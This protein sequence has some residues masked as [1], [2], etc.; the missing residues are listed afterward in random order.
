MKA[1]AVKE[2]L[3]KKFKSGDLSALRDLLESERDGLYDYLLRMTGQVSRSMETT[4]EV[5]LS[6]NEDTLDVTDNYTELK[7][8]LYTTAR[9]FNADIWNAETSR[10]KNLA[11]EGPP[12]PDDG[13]RKAMRERAI[14][15]V[16]DRQLRTL[17]GR[18]RDLLLLH[19]FAYFDENEISEIT[20]LSTT[21]V[22]SLLTSGMKHLVNENLAFEAVT[23]TL[24]LVPLHPLPPRSSQA[25]ID[26]SM[27]MQGIKTKPE[28]LWS[29]F[30]LIVLL[31][32]AAA[33]G[34]W[35]LNPEFIRRTLKLGL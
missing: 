34:L 8:L 33:I 9:K 3:Y 15:S 16:V 20:S 7:I 11:L 32:I 17:G 10:L 35:L 26:L 5:F 12:G 13:T 6:L 30:K 29:P 19:G 21:E 22:Q 4:D 27:V 14:L 1:N 25:T 2:K 31:L 23:A 18:E 24:G 28:G